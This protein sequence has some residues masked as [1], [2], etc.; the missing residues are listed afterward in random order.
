MVTSGQRSAECSV[1]ITRRARFYTPARRM[2]VLAA[3]F[4]VQTALARPGES[5]TV[6]NA[7]NNFDYQERTGFA[8]AFD[9]RLLSLDDT[10]ALMTNALAGATS[11]AIDDWQT[12]IQRLK[13]GAPQGRQS[14]R[15]IR[16]YSDL[17]VYIKEGFALIPDATNTEGAT[18]ADDF[19]PERDCESPDQDPRHSRCI[20]LHRDHVQNIDTNTVLIS[21][22]T[23]IFSGPSA[24]GG[25]SLITMSE[26]TWMP[27]ADDVLDLSARQDPAPTIGEVTSDRARRGRCGS[28]GLR[29]AARRRR[30][31]ANFQ[32]RCK[33]RGQEHL[34]N[35]RR[36]GRHQGALCGDL[37]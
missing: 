11:T 5:Q 19:V 33:C 26:N 32:R 20:A 31:D 14:V 18:S 10:D 27:T 28:Y 25:Q 12:V 2:I 29:R 7:P 35:R 15:A 1:G 13:F 4:A 34:R 24:T 36:L 17:P 8:L 9:D 22:R 16:V 21:A 37:R 6:T 3:P 23:I 30:R